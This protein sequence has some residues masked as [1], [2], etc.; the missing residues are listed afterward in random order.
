MSKRCTHES[1]CSNKAKGTGE[2]C[3]EHINEAIKDAEERLKEAVE[4]F[5]NTHELVRKLKSL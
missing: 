4:Q 5:N 2:L 1:Q 3:E